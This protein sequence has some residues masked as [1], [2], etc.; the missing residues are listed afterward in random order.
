MWPCLV[1]AANSVWEASTSARVYWVRLSRRVR[2]PSR[3]L[4]RSLVRN[5]EHVADHPHRQWETQACPADPRADRVRPSLDE[6]LGHRLDRRGAWA[7]VRLTVNHLL[8]IRRHRWWRLTAAGRAV[9][10]ACRT[11]ARL[12]PRPG[13][14]LGAPV[15]RP[16]RGSDQTCRR[17]R[18]ASAARLVPA[19]QRHPRDRAA[20]SQPRPFRGGPQRAPDG[21]WIV[22]TC[23]STFTLRHRHNPWCLLGATRRHPTTR[24]QL[25]LESS[26]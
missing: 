18:S 7:A 4:S 23:S 20:L 26:S 24:T 13:R 15:P 22:S 12:V 25:V 1:R 16:N 6:A 14:V 5:P 19:G 8:I 11:P 21:P 9:A 3:K 10:I 2:E 17:R